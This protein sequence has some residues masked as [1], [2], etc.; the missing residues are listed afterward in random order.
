MKRTDKTVTALLR[1]IESGV[2]IESACSIAGIHRSTWY[3]W[4]E[5]P[6]LELRISQALAKAEAALLGTIRKAGETDWRASAWILERRY[7]DTWGKRQE[8]QAG[9]SLEVVIRRGKVNFTSLSDGELE[10]IAAGESPRDLH[11][12]D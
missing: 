5:R 7:S 6:E 4:R 11:R 10:R 9:G 3:E 12:A 2:S 8:V 1:A